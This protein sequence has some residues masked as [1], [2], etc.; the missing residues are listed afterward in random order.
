MVSFD[1]A[2]RLSALWR[3]FLEMHNPS[4]YQVL[5]GRRILSFVIKDVCLSMILR[6]SESY[7]LALPSTSHSD[8]RKSQLRSLKT[9]LLYLWNETV[10]RVL[11]GFVRLILQRFAKC[12]PGGF[13]LQSNNNWSS[14]ASGE[15]RNYPLSRVINTSIVCPRKCVDPQTFWDNPCTSREL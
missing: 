11:C 13:H 7:A 15:C 4:I 12:S 5:F 2:K 3:S 10:F 6:I 14:T 1:S 9:I 8:D